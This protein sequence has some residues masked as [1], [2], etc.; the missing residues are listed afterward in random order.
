MHGILPSKVILEI[1]CWKLH[2]GNTDI[3]GNTRPDFS[4]I[5]N[6]VRNYIECAYIYMDSLDSFCVPY[7]L[8]MYVRK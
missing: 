7:S 8:S 4:D 5:G 6:R 3:E 2:I 1:R